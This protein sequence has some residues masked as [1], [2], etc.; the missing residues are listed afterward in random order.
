MVFGIENYIVNPYLRA[1][2]VLVGVFIVLKILFWVIEKVLIRITAKT[3]TNVDDIFL[4]K[5]SKPTTLL[6]LLIGF[7]IA[8]QEL[9]FSENVI[10]LANKILLS[11]I[12]FSVGYLIYVFINVVLFSILKQRIGKSKKDAALR[13]SL[14][15]MSR[16]FLSVIWVVLALLYVLEVWGIE[17]GP[18]L[19]GLG[20]AGVAIAFAMQSSLSNIFG[21]I[22]MILDRSIKVGDLVYLE[23]LTKGK[24]LNV[25]FRSTRILTFDNETIILPNS[26]V[27]DGKIQ[28]IGEPEPKSRVVIPFGVAYG[29]DIE[30]V[31]KIV[32]TELKK[33]KD[34]EKEPEPV[35]RFLEMGDSSLNFKAYFYVNTFENR[36]EAVDEANTRIYNALNK[37]KIEIPFPQVDVHLR[38]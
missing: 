24:V 25:G 11:F 36:I 22:S 15:S 14:M 1:L 23:D 6:V 10:G 5:A 9:P 13:E 12:V 20:I 37:N 19:A 8:I 18:F 34:F 38:K 4:A 2:A 26:K 21:G 31:K 3:K 35:V 16:S 28:N 32:L 33:I 29:A 7:M 27:A 30:K 17:I